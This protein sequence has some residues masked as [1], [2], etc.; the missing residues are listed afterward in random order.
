[1]NAQPHR[2]Q[3]SRKTWL[4]IDTVNRVTAIAKIFSPVETDKLNGASPQAK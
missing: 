3:R 2:Q 1:L 4:F